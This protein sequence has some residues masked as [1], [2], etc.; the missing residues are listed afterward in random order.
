MNDEF[1]DAALDKLLR[2]ADPLAPGDLPSDADTDAALR[3]LV[4]GAPAPGSGPGRGKRRREVA[5]SLRSLRPRVLASLTGCAAVIATAVAVLLGSGGAPA[6]AVTRNSDGTVSVKLMSIAGV[7]GANHAL[8]SLGVRARFVQ[9]LATARYVAQTQPCKGL[10]AGA[11][12]TI[13]IN[14][15]SIPQGR[16]EALAVDHAAQVRFYA[17]VPAGSLSAVAARVHAMALA[18]G[19]AYQRHFQVVPPGTGIYGTGNS[20][21][22]DS[23]SGN[24]GTGNSGAQ[25]PVGNSGTGNSGSGNSGTGNSGTGQ[26]IQLHIHPGPR[27]V[28]I[29]CGR[30]GAPPAAGNSGTGNSGN[31]GTGN[32]GTG[33]TGTGK[34]GTGNTGT[35]NSGS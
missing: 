6:Y 26:T 32:S 4:A 11:E 21:T 29:Y 8:A 7:D 1:D 19:K 22:G 20:G 30:A 5:G 35:G 34:S 2:A 24:S 18:S 14:P 12:R 3:R 28:T 16:L 13:T 17:A 33:N 31:T 15:A 23:G 9:V 10:P 27:L 25:T